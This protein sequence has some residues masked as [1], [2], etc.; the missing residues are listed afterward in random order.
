V[1]EAV[2]LTSNEHALA[3]S[4]PAPVHP[5]TIMESLNSDVPGALALD[6]S[7]RHARC[8]EPAGRQQEYTCLN[9]VPDAVDSR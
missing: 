2:D 3:S 8:I 5:E 9:R 4:G 1:N 7:S 6:H